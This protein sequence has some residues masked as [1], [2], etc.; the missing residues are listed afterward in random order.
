MLGVDEMMEKIRDD[1]CDFWRFRGVFNTYLASLGTLVDYNLA[2]G[3]RSGYQNFIP[4]WKKY[5][6][7]GCPG[8]PP[9]K[10]M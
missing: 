2:N 7:S 5:S 9:C 10:P 4:R 3:P 6:C 1:L 8:I